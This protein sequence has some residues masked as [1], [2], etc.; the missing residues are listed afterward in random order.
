MT[1]DQKRLEVVADALEH[2]TPIPGHAAYAPPAARRAAA[3]AASPP[4]SVSTTQAA[5]DV[6]RSVSE[7][8]ER[9]QKNMVDLGADLEAAI[10]ACTAMLEKF[11]RA[12]KELDET[13]QAYREEGKRIHDEINRCAALAESVSHLCADVRGKIKVQP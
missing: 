3:R 12:T 7:E 10:A 11:Q 9:V 4:P 6:A 2:H 5:Q 8:Y 1:D 13:V